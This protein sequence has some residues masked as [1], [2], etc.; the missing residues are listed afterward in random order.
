MSP[1]R[2]CASSGYQYQSSS[3]AS[4]ARKFVGAYNLTSP[5]LLAS[6]SYLLSTSYDENDN[7]EENETTSNAASEASED[8]LSICG[9]VRTDAEKALEV[10]EGEEDAIVADI[11]LNGCQVKAPDVDRGPIANELQPS[12][13][14]ST[15]CAHARTNAP[16]LRRASSTNTRHHHYIPVRRSKRLRGDSHDGDEEEEEEAQLR[17][18]IAESIKDAQDL[19]VIP[20]KEESC[21]EDN[22]DQI[23]NV[24]EVQEQGVAPFV[25][26]EEADTVA[27]PCPLASTSSATSTTPSSHLPDPLSPPPPRRSLPSHVELDTSFPGFYTRYK[28]P[29]QVP[30]SLHAS[31]F[32]PSIDATSSLSFGGR[33]ARY[34]DARWKALSSM[35][36]RGPIAAA[37]QD[38][39]FRSST[40][41]IP[42][43]RTAAETLWAS[44]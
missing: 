4:P 15:P 30:F 28:V 25:K 32:P 11:N 40:Y 1:L 7:A 20:K 2:L 26:T 18:V 36:S 17:R 9:D 33:K 5:Q 19:D 14:T 13:N 41:P 16:T 22:Q 23:D 31:I 42:A 44:E 6:G 37:G 34:V 29:C 21:A 3:L 24:D 8:Q 12:T 43:S 35:M 10:G 27:A 38:G 39:S